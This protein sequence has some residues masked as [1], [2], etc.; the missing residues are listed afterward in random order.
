[1]DLMGTIKKTGKKV[2]QALTGE[3]PAP[4]ETDILDTLKQEHN[5]V[6]ELLTKLVDSQRGAERKS[7]LR[8]IKQSLVPHV[9]AEET[10]LYDAILAL[11]D[12]QS[13]QNGEEGYIEHGLADKMLGALGKITNAMSPEFSAAAKVLKELVEHHI[14]E[15]ERNVWANARE[16]FSDEE[17]M[18]MNQRFLAAKKRVRLPA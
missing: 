12:K 16:N 14:D 15:E 8:R 3:E 6:K 7:L 10:V 2:G 4:G 13:K 5:E 11:R 9:R 18:A 17:R 1:M